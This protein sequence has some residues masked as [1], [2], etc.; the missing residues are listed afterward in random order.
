MLMAR[1]AGLEVPVDE[2]LPAGLAE[3]EYLRESI[4]PTGCWR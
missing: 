3:L 2:D 4:G 1:E